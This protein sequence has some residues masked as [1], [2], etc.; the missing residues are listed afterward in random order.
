MS[1]SNRLASV[2]N[3]A[4]SS[5]R[6]LHSFSVLY[7]PFVSFNCLHVSGEMAK[8]TSKDASNMGFCSFLTDVGPI[9]LAYIALLA[10]VKRKIVGMC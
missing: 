6:A 8:Q 5:T 2:A 9:S 7:G 4:I 10:Q 1:N 3:A